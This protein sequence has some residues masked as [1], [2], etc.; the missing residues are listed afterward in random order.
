M[1]EQGA[2]SIRHV[3]GA[4]RTRG[5]L[6]AGPALLLGLLAFLVTV[7]VR[8]QR[9]ASEEVARRRADLARVVE[10]RQRRAADLE[11]GLA[12]LRA[13]ADVLAERSAQRALTEL[14]R[15]SERIAALS[16]A[17]AV[18]GPGVVVVLRDAS[19]AERSQD[20][21]DADFRIQDLDVQAAVN[22]LWAAGAEAIAVNG[23]RV[24]ATTAIRNAGGALLVNYRV[25][26][27][28]YRVAAIGDRERVRARFERSE[29]ARRF[30]GWAD[31][32]GLGFEVRAQ[33]RLEL[34]AF[35]G[36]LRYRYARPAEGDG[37]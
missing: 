7:E 36:V 29:A 18:S 20:P 13:R 4:G 3:R 22:A 14:R 23:Q 30:R 12:S 28:P 5:P 33:G 34:P 15:A 26:T 27:S 21:D 6:G 10:A 2:P 1:T 16:G 9:S 19:G 8:E 31:I 11:R 17:R 37:G 35:T 32:Y 25:L 24:V